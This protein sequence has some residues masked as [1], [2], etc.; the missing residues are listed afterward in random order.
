VQVGLHVHHGNAPFPKGGIGQAGSDAL[1]VD[2]GGAL[3][4]RVKRT[5]GDERSFD[6]RI[7]VTQAVGAE[8]SAVGAQAGDGLAD[9][10]L[11]GGPAVLGQTGLGEGSRQQRDQNKEGDAVP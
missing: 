5:G 6:A 7:A 11:A 3:A 10:L 9:E 8:V 2:Q 4:G 1:D